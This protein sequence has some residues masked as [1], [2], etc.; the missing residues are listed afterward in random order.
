MEFA[1]EIIFNVKAKEEYIAPEERKKMSSE[2]SELISFDKKMKKVS[3]EVFESMKSTYD[4][5][6][7]NDY[8]DDYHM[9]EEDRKRRF[10]YYEVFSK[11]IRCK[12]KYRKLDEFVK[13]YRLC[14]DCLNIVAKDNGIYSEEK[15]V[16]LVLRNQIE[17]FGL[18]FP[19]YV[20]KDRKDINWSYI[21][22]FILDRDLD[23][24]ELKPK[25]KQ[26][27]DD[28]DEIDNEM[29]F[30]DEE[31]AA[32]E[33][34]FDEEAEYEGETRFHDE[35]DEDIEGL[36][37]VFDK[38][39]Q[40]KFI[41]EFPEVMK[42]VQEAIKE[43]HKSRLMSNRLNRMIYEIDEDDYEAIRRMDSERG[44]ESSS[45]MPVF[46]GDLMNRD[47]Y[48]KF[49]MELDR[50]ERNEIKENYHGKMRTKAEIQEIELKEALEEAGWNLRVLWNNKDKEKKLKKAYKKD[51]QREKDLKRRLIEIENRQKKRSKKA[52]LKVNSKKKKKKKKND[53]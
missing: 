3:P 44:F 22:N 40:K 1:D 21:S 32:F 42:T 18:H 2:Q 53:E 35:E 17:V 39:D 11:V 23:P 5:V 25:N 10:K 34:S 7:V 8:G 48:K 26:A 30:T 38:D 20:G 15:F 31:I 36:A 29:L 33:K 43:D 46:H 49:L 50:Y 37:F 45:D 9:S 52:D 24:N 47:D 51:K 14:L 19:K 12:R 6:V 16:K 4:E 41:K 28:E 13:V 27:D